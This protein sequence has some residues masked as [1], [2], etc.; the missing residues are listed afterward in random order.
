MLSFVCE[1]GKV[2]ERDEKYKENDNVLFRWKLKYCDSCLDKKIDKALDNLPKI[3]K[4]L[5]D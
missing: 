1:C 3:L 2:F 5:S 4:I